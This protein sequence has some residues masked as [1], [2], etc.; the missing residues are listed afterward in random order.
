MTVAEQTE[1]GLPANYYPNLLSGGTG[2][3]SKTPDQRISNVNAIPAGPFQLTNGQTFTYDSYAASPVHRFYQMW[4]Q[5]N[6][7]LSNGELRQSV[8]LQRQPVCLGRSDRRRGHQWHQAA[9]EF[10]TEYS[11]SA[12]TTGEGSTALGFYNVQQGDV[13]YFTSL[14]ENY[15]MSD[16]FHQSV[17]GGTGANHIMFG[18]ADAIWF[19]DGNGHPLAPPNGVQVFTRTPPMRARSTRSKTRTRRPAPT[20]GIRKTVT[21]RATMPDIR[22]PIRLRRSTAAGHTAIARIPPSPASSRS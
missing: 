14:V 18:H 6:C 17:N 7:S 19:S 21:A 1:S 13:P 16:N 15:A 12:T 10:S 20:T 8:G 9:G 3:T 5:L 4:Q 2:Q 22:R 11:P